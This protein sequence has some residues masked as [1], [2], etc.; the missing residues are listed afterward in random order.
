[1]NG[2]RIWCEA[3]ALND[4]SRSSRPPSRAAV[5][6]RAAPTSSASRSPLGLG[7]IVK[8]PVPSARA[9]CVRLLQRCGDPAGLPPGEQ[10]R[11]PEH[12]D[13]EARH[14]DPGPV[15]AGED[16]VVPGGGSHGGVPPPDPYR[17]G[18]RQLVAGERLVRDGASR[19]A[20]L[21]GELRA[22]LVAVEPAGR[23]GERHREQRDREHGHQQD[24][25][26]HPPP[27]R[28]AAGDPAV[29]PGDLPSVDLRRTPR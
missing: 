17:H 20:C 24:R 27:H 22:R 23:D 1:M 3:S 18:D 2:V 28:P 29:R 15:G 4:R 26:P 25:R 13:R 6:W 21:A 7:R 5:D 16:V 12:G 9:A 11:D 14:R 10:R 19:P 8:S